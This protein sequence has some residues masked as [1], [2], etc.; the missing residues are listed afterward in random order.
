MTQE[1]VLIWFS[2]LQN[3][4]LN[5]IASIFTFM[6]NE[7]FYF[8]VIPFVYICFSKTVGFR[9]LYILLFSMYV[10]TFIKIN[11]AAPRPVNVEGVN[12]LFI[13]SADSHFY[14]YDSFPS[15]HAQGSATLFGYLAYTVQNKLFW[16]V[17][18]FLVFFISISRLYVGMHWPID[19]ISG[20]LLA[21]FLLVI[22]IRVE[23]FI[24]TRSVRWQWILA[25][26]FPIVLFIIFPY[27]KGAKYAGF[28]LG[29]GVAYLLERDYIGMKISPVLW[30]KVVSFGVMLA[31]LMA[32][33]AGVKQI[34]PETDL[35]NAL[36]Y[37]S[38]GVWGL[39]VAPWLLV[40][41]RVLSTDKQDSNRIGKPPVSA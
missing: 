28:L 32:L 3:S 6:G 14:P 10:N 15:G 20:A 36:R 5:F 34:F 12:P 31:G 39:L 21:I 37:G 7:P 22:A 19:V 27:D 38:M 24:T 2:S 8:L 29:A 30:R 9:L 40:K 4:V 17:A 16:I 33:Q 11:V 35:F 1:S 18:G 23:R 13:E 26:V 25:L 41:L